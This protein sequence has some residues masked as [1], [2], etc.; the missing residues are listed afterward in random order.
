VHHDVIIDQQLAR[1]RRRVKFVDLSVT[2][3]VLVGGVILYALAIVLVDHWVLELSTLGRITALVL[4]L[5]GAGFYCVR[6]V[7]PL[8][9]RHINPSFAAR[10]IE[11]SNPSLKNS[12][13]NFLMF[14]REPTPTGRLVYRALQQRAAL[15]LRNVNVDLA[16]DKSRLIHV[17]YLVSA[18]MILFAAYTILSPKDVFQTIRR[19]SLP[20]ADISRPT[21]VTIDEVQP[22]DGNPILGSQV[23]ISA[24][25]RGVGTDDEVRLFYTTIDNQTV[26]RQVPMQ[27]A[28]TGTRYS[29]T[30][31]GG[32][33]GIQQSLS[34]HIEAGDATS[35]EFLLT[36][37]QT[38]SIVV[39]K[40]VYDYPNYMDTPSH[41]TEGEGEIRGVEGTT[42]TIHAKANHP[43]KDAAI[44]FD[45]QDNAPAF[46]MESD[47]TTA[48]YRFQ[49]R[50]NDARNAAQYT[51][52]QLEFEPE[53]ADAARNA[54]HQARP[55]VHKILVTPDLSPEIS[56]LSPRRKVTDVAVNGQ[57]RIEIR[58][59]DPD[60]GLTDLTLQI[61]SDGQDDATIPFPLKPQERRGQVVRVYEFR[62]AELGYEPGDKATFWA[63]AIDNCFDPNLAR[64]ADYTL[65]I[66]PP[67]ERQR[68]GTEKSDSPGVGE[69]Q[70]DNQS[71]AP[72]GAAQGNSQN[73]SATSDEM[74]NQDQ[75]SS[76]QSSSQEQ[77]EQGDQQAGG[78]DSS[79]G[80]SQEAGESGDSSSNQQQS[81]ASGEQTEG[82]QTGEGGQQEA[83][84]SGGESGSQPDNG[85]AGSA[86]NQA[87]SSSGASGESASQSMP[88]SD[89]SSDAGSGGNDSQT[90]PSQGGSGQ[91]GETADPAAAGS[92]NQREEPLHDGE[93]IERVL[94]HMRKSGQN[95]SDAQTGDQ[96]QSADPQPSNSNSNPGG[97]N[98]QPNQQNGDNGGD[99]SQQDGTAGDSAGDPRPGDSQPEPMPGGAQADQDPQG[100]KPAT[101]DTPSDSPGKQPRHLG[102]GQNPTPQQGGGEKLATPEQPEA[103]EGAE[104]SA[105]D[106]PQPGEKNSGVGDEGDA[107]A[108]RPSANETG[109][110]E[111]QKLNRDRDKPSRP[112]NQESSDNEAQSPSQSRKQS[113]STGDQGGDES[114]G[115]EQGGGQ[116]ADQAGR[117]SP[118]SNTS[119]DQ[120]NTG[121]PESGEGETADRGGDKQRSP[122]QTGSSG[123]DAGEGSQSRSAP[124]QQPTPDGAMPK[125]PQDDFDPDQVESP[126][127]QQQQDPNNRTPG[128]MSSG[129]PDGGGIPSDAVNIPSQSQT[130]L[131]E[132][133]AANLDYARKA[134][135]MVLEHLKDQQQQP[136][137]ELLKSLGWTG[138]ELQAF[139]NRWENMKRNAQE[140]GGEAGEELDDALRSLG[141]RR[142]GPGPRAANANNDQLRGMQDGGN[143]SRP[144]SDILEKFNAYRKGAA[145]GQRPGS[146]Y[147]Q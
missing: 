99:Q 131:L 37:M 51:S 109:S 82:S 42:V 26:D 77:G 67:D 126:N 27:L 49:L 21:R 35:P 86:G 106:T 3:M 119:S 44:K 107:G 71:T 132:G 65:N 144:P 52:Y 137:P 88:P 130:P 58:A 85:S 62:P 100:R 95:D 91:A 31:P 32:P 89:G 4:L 94:E 46:R 75:T 61:R 9:L 50:W 128:G 64:T 125:P 45:P 146:G 15:D 113:D 117:D 72:D 39:Q 105:N 73:D 80:E 28:G 17:G 103:A 120:G 97:Q 127:A 20:W 25:V 6:A 110:T 79:A 143:R 142:T 57:Q 92:Q 54:S 16:V 87:G 114:G 53:L 101:T 56:I 124:G 8:V 98:T 1:T 123:R 63:E 138:D 24:R 134:T 2:L 136:D 111:S 68:S 147:A 81:A 11:Q 5:V 66:L 41:T 122:D 115:G 23:E 36:M 133:D 13:I 74:Q 112:Q 59:L 19:I 34:Y 129:N 90:G 14:R 70:E 104:T 18:L 141:L 108:G 140:H 116:S 30:I 69:N 55:A 121:S 12:L 47:G 135:D 93:A 78:G 43:I 60:F 48:R 76:P 102:D 10:A 29:C 96:G 145:R 22:G 40:I 139:I 84:D 118:G 38:P 83:G 7:F 33:A